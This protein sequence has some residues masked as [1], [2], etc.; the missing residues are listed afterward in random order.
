MTSFIKPHTC[1]DFYKIGHVSMYE[2]RTEYVYSNC[3]PRSDRLAKT[4]GEYY[5]QK[6]VSV[7]LQAF[8][9]DYLI[10]DW[11]EGFFNR[12]KH[13]VVNEYKSRVSNGLV[14]SNPK[15]DHIEALHDL[16]YLPIS[17]KALPEGALVNIKV[18]LFT[19]VNT[20]PAFFWLTNFLES[21]IQA[22]IWKPVTSATTSYQYRKLLEDF[23]RKTGSPMD[24]VLWQAHDFSFRGMSG[25]YD[26]AASGYAHLLSFYGTDTIPAM[27]YADA[28]YS[29]ASTFIGGSVPASEHSVMT[30]SGAA[31]EKETFRRL[32]QDT[33]PTGV[34]S[35][36]SDSY[37]YW[38]ALTEYA[39][40]LKDAIMAR[41]P[42]AIGLAKVVFRPDSGDPADI[43]C[44]TVKH[45]YNTLDDAVADLCDEVY[46]RDYDVYIK[47]TDK[48]FTLTKGDGNIVAV[49]P[50]EATPEQKG[51]VQ[52][53]WEIF[54][55]TIT[56]TVH[57]LLDSHVGLIYGDSITLERAKDILS[58]LEAKG[59]ASANIVFGVGSYTFQ[60]VTRDTYGIAMKAT[61]GIVDGVAREVYK[62]PKTDVG[63]VKKSARGLLRVEKEGDDYVLYDQQTPEQEAQGEL[64]EIFRNSQMVSLTTLEKS[65]NRLHPA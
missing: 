56:E 33:F 19:V 62:D 59:F 64:K 49:I 36:V 57:R 20:N 61:N 32:L 37:D 45:V 46:N 55:G 53:L 24:F 4:L 52:V 38:K 47:G 12:P 29:G 60:Y 25:R 21:V 6:V 63:G 26:A 51:S 2:A 35:I 27:D 17:I 3:T 44:G 28:F 50:F 54:G 11:N 8:C 65:R 22:E 5:N 31:D 30:L 23:A 1:A 7:G 43:I 40:E 18:P 9:I 39:A 15:T 13:E 16:G 58:R 14:V 10:N 42:N 48:Y 41:Q 34:I